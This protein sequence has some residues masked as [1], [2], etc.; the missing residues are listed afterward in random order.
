[1]PGITIKGADSAGGTQLAGGQGEF[2]VNGQPVVVKGDPIAGHGKAPHSAPVMAE[3]SSWMTWNGITVVRAGHLA[4]CGHAT[5]GQ[6][7]WEID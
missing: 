3:G 4:T 2:T 7:N 1:M 6:S 5:T